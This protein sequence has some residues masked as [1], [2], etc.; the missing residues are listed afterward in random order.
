MS[1]YTVNVKHNS[2]LILYFFLKVTIWRQIGQ[3]DKSITGLYG[4]YITTCSSPCALNSLMSEWAEKFNNIK[5]E[6]D[7][8]MPGPQELKVV[9]L[10]GTCSNMW[11]TAVDNKN[12]MAPC[13]A[14]EYGISDEYTYIYTGALFFHGTKCLMNTSKIRMIKL[15]NDHKYCRTRGPF[16]PNSLTW[17]NS[18]KYRP[19]KFSLYIY[20]ETAYAPR[21][22]PI[23]N[24]GLKFEQLL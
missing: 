8:L 9:C 4:T 22:W 19:F 2:V 10:K 5:I 17:V 3:S 13:Y 16:D 11:S 24:I 15:E 6:N 12:C 20:K 23:L 21:G 1:I 14:V 18:F 7:R